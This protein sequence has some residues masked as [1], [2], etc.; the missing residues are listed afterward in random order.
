MS[1]RRATEVA[2]KEIQTY[3]SGLRSATP[4]ARSSTGMQAGN[5]ASARPKG[6]TWLAREVSLQQAVPDPSQFQSD[7]EPQGDEFEDAQSCQDSQNPEA[8]SAV[9]E[10]RENHGSQLHSINVWCRPWRRTL[11]RPN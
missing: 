3:Y 4:L 10:G 1:R 6:R 2:A 7:S 11:N 9:T 8:R 5:A